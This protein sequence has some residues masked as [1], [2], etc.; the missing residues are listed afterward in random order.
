MPRHNRS[1]YKSIM[2][3]DYLICGLRVRFIVPWAVKISDESRPFLIAS[4]TPGQV[5]LTVRFSAVDSL[6][7]PDAGGAW[8]VNSYF[9]TKDGQHRIWHYPVR[10]DSP[11]CCVI[12]NQTSADTVICRYVRGREDQIAYTRNLLELL[13]LE[14][15]L[16]QFD[17]LILHASLVKWEGRG[18]L[19]CAPSGTGKSTQAALWT[20]YIGSQTLNGDRAGIRCDG[21]VWNAWG[22]PFA[23]TSGIYCNESV[24]IKAVVLLSQGSENAISSVGALSAFKR[25]LP[26]CSAQRWDAGFMD[27]LVNILSALSSSVPVFELKCRADYGAVQLLADTICKEG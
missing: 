24:P 18:I 4:E 17:A 6:D 25:M 7:T 5:D 12:W 10:N 19:F 9:L 14:C 2:N 13:G 8:S 15:F 21:G 22:L 20:Q 16:L 27:R 26:E 11:Y 1:F 23:G 3:Y